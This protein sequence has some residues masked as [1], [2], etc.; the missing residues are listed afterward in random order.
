MN[1]QNKH[2]EVVSYIR[3][4]RDQHARVPFELLEDERVS[5]DA[6][7]IYVQ[8]LKYANSDKRAFPKQERLAKDCGRSRP[9]VIKNLK[10]LEETGWLSVERG[11][12][13]SKQVNVYTLH[14]SACRVNED[15]T[16]CKRG[17]HDRVNDVD[18]NYDQGTKTNELG[19]SQP[20]E[21]PANLSKVRLQ[22]MI[23]S[24]YF[25]Q[26]FD[27]FWEIYPRR[28]GKRAAQEALAKIMLDGSVPFERIVA[29]FN[30][31]AHHY[32]NLPVNEQKFQKHPA[33]WL[34]QGCWDDEL[35]A[36]PKAS[37]IIG[38]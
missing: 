15:D 30:L 38:Y 33:T 5:F 3:A 13:G 16:S 32:K 6:R 22:K 10:I 14:R 23:N 18:T 26:C 21:K 8:L 20:V 2:D 25:Q 11:E 27:H 9:W 17:L 4:E 34:N 36:T 31:A 12:Q 28:V 19:D 35:P 24:D 29:G 37:P 7:G 1:Y